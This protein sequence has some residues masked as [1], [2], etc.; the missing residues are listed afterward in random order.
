MSMNLVC[1][2]CHNVLIKKEKSYTCNN[3]HNFDIAK[4]GYINLYLKKSD[5][6][7]NKLMVD[8]RNNFLNQGYYSFLAK[9][10]TKTIKEY[11][12]NNVVDLACGDGYYT[13]Q[14]DSKHIGID[15]SKNALKIASRNDKEGTYILSSIFDLP[16]EDKCADF[17][18]TCFAPI[19]EKQIKRILK[20]NSYFLYVGPGEN[21][22]KQLKEL[23]Y[24]NVYLNEDKEIINLNL[25]K[26][27][28]IENKALIKK[29]DV[30]NLFMMTPYFYNSSSD[31]LNKLK[32]TEITFQFNLK[33]YSS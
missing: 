10:I 1:P 20:D 19:A 24:Q 5:G 4:Q 13:K 29:E 22:L 11:N 17:V 14:I 18:L 16:L 25:I 30:I 26:Q 23:L 9:E 33:L 28:T 15:L 6:G 27:W 12:A 32:E 2:V 31:S 8:A 7:D 3:K 21:H